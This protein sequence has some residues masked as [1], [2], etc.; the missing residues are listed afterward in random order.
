MSCGMRWS[1]NRPNAVLQRGHNI[2]RTHWRQPLE[3]GQWRWSWSICKR[4]PRRPQMAQ[5][6]PWKAIRASCSATVSPCAVRRCW[7]PAVGR[8][9]DALARAGGLPER[10]HR[11]HTGEGIGDGQAGV[12]ERLEGPQQPG[13]QRDPLRLGREVTGGRSGVPDIRL[14]RPAPAGTGGLSAGLPASACSRSASTSSSSGSPGASMG[15]VGGGCGSGAWRARCLDAC[16]CMASS[17]MPR[18]T[19]TERA[20]RPSTSRAL[21]APASGRAHT[22]H[23]RAIRGSGPRYRG[24]PIR[25]VRFDAGGRSREGHF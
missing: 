22:E 8:S 18:S 5:A 6:P 21:T 10:G 12:G 24:M 2:P 17:D 11:V 1:P 9:Q 20:E 13:P 23:L 7:G 15:G 25:G 4:S 3:P 14:G 19:A 16:R